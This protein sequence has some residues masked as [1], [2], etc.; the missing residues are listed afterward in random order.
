ME[1][2]ATTLSFVRAPLADVHVPVNVVEPPLAVRLVISPLALVH[3]AVRP[4]LKSVPVP[5]LLAPLPLIDD[6]VVEGPPPGLAVHLLARLLARLLNRAVVNRAVRVDHAVGVG[7]IDVHLDVRYLES[8]EDILRVHQRVADDKDV[9]R[10]IDAAGCSAA[11]AYLL[12]LAHRC[13]E[14]LVV[15]CVAHCG[16]AAKR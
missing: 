2:D 10:A 12:A 7:G 1:V 8:W 6:P 16:I 4:D 13:R 11:V 5:S 14:A 9:A 3:R 15:H